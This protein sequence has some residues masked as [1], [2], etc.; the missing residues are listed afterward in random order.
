MNVMSI[1]SYGGQ[2]FCYVGINLTIF[3]WSFGVVFEVK[4]M[5]KRLIERREMRWQGTVR[6]VSCEDG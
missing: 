1:L 6:R 3:Y 4:D 5:R 2:V